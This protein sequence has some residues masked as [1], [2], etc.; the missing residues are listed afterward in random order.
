MDRSRAAAFFIALTTIL[1]CAPAAAQS[2]ADTEKAR[3]LVGEGRR[4]FGLREYREAIQALWAAYRITHEPH[5]LFEIGQSYRFAGN[6]TEAARFY[7]DYLN[8][9]PNPPNLDEIEAGLAACQTAGGAVAPP[10]PP[11]VEPPPPQTAVVATPVSTAAPRPPQRTAAL[12]IGGI[13]VASLVIGTAFAVVAQSGWS[14][15]QARCPNNVCPNPADVALPDDVRRNGN[16]ATAGFVIGG[17]G[18]ATAAILWFTAPAAE[19]AGASSRIKVA[20]AVSAGTFGLSVG[21]RF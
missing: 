5:L 11:P 7:N 9:V 16:I 10:T 17:V 18:L 1:W 19:P 13:G 2:A 20:P 14:D 6:C 21:G 15:A 12:V 8:Q 3:D 4:H